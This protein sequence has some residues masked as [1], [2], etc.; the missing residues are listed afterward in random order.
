MNDLFD[1]KNETFKP[2]LI[3]KGKT[4]FS[5]I[6][7][8]LRLLIDAP[9]R[10]L[11]N[12]FKKNI[13]LLKGNNV[14]DIGCG[15]KFYKNFIPD[16]IH[17]VGLE[18]ENSKK[19]LNNGSEVVIYDGKTIPFENNY[20]NNIICFEVLEHVFDYD[21]FIREVSR[22]SKQDSVLMLSVPFAAKF[23]LI[24]DDYFRYTPS[25]I[26]LILEKHNYKIENFIRRG[27]DIIVTLHFILV[28]I[29]GLILQ[30]KII[31]SL[32][33]LIFLPIGIISALSINLI[34]LFNLGAKEN[35]LGFFIIAKK[36]N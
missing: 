11:I 25:S 18:I 17:Y 27:D 24:P 31:H 36:I 26:K 9:H 3:S 19:Y 12:N 29:L 16:N 1:Y 30:R 14:L 15:T 34:E 13:H 2:F 10:S 33:G 4:F 6:L 20:F 5:K 21:S 8:Y 32:L 23:H 35:C 28:A 7:Y 22:V